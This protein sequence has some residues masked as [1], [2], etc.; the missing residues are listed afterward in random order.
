MVLNM[1]LKSGIRDI[2]NIMELNSPAHLETRSRLRSTNY[3]H[4]FLKGFS[5]K[6]ILR[7]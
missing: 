6:K 5:E 1:P 2:F 7:V 4:I 3:I